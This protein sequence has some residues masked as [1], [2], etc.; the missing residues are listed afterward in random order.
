M[1]IKEISII[2]GK[3]GTGKT[4]L[5]A[6]IIP[7]LK[8]IVIA[9]ADVDAPDLKIL[10]DNEL[11]SSEDFIGLQRAKINYDTCIN[12]GR[13]STVCNFGAISKDI[14]VN[15]GKCEGCTVCKVAC[16]VNAITME[17]YIVGKVFTRQT[18]YGPMVDARL[19][20]GEEASGRLVSK[21]RQLSKEIG[22]NQQKEYILLDG[23][24]GIACN[25]I[26]AITGANKVVIVTEPTLSGLHD[27]KRVLQLAKAFSI[28]PV[29][30]I[31]K[32]GI[33]STMENNIKEY[34]IETNIPIML[35]IPFD[36]KMVESVAR[37]EIPSL[38]NIQYFK[39]EEWKQFIDYLKK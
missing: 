24:P 35:E 23:S 28:E 16:P 19:I 33:E 32:C 39:E 5:T 4:T 3:G 2:S 34:C 36:R 38:S 20:P 11:L 8:N 15:E 13:C 37:K 7:F 31:N 22:E 29:V 18:K 6:S 14:V 12:C 26:S 25:V 1:S 10:L 30:V 21:V 17:D 27:L 9:D